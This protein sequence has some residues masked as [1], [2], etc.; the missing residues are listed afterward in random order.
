MFLLKKHIS[1]FVVQFSRSNYHPLSR[2]ALLL[3]HLLLPLSILFLKF[4]KKIFISFFSNIRASFWRLI[5]VSRTSSIVNT[6]FVIFY[7]FLL[8]LLFL[9]FSTPPFVHCVQ[10]VCCFYLIRQK[11]SRISV[12]REE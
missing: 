10:F 3:Y 2:T 9:L 4:L 8:L 7:F 1:S 12:L 11:S 5:S 6:F